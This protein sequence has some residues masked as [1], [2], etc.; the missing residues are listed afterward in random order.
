[1]HTKKKKT[2]R[3]IPYC[4]E[5]DQHVFVQTRDGI[6]WRK[7]RR[8]G[9]LNDSLATNVDLSKISGPAA[10]KVINKLRPYFNGLEPG[11]I[12][13]RIINSL[14]KGLKEHKR[15][16][17]SSLLAMEI[18][19]DHSLDQLLIGRYSIEKNKENLSIS[20]AITKDT[21]K[22]YNRLVTHYFFEGVIISGNAGIENGL[23]VADMESGVYSFELQAKE[24]CVI[25]L[26]LPED[27]IPWMAL[28]KVSCMEGNEMAV[29]PRH[30]GMKVV[31]VGGGSV[32]DFT[33][34]LNAK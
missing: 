29:H 19:R 34:S 6:H 1:M 31:A 11:R 14:K 22:R 13:L 3:D 18:Q 27:G 25:N 17:L 32:E 21:I 23:S 33:R 12:T 5:P 8:K 20:I 26:P 15:I 28:L 2:R 30:Y 10:R 4:A 7:K 16:D 24:H 9:K